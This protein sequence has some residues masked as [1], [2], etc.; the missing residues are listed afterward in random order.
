MPTTNEATGLTQDARTREDS[1]PI[2]GSESR[3]VIATYPDYAGAERAVD[4]LSD[5]GFAV[6]HVAIVGKG[7]RS[8]EQVSSRMSGARAALIGAGY[9]ALIGALFA[10]LFGIFFDGPNFGGLLLYSVANGVIFG[11]LLAGMYYVIESDGSRDFVSETSIVADRYEVHADE[12]VADEAKRVLSTM[13]GR[14]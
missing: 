12:G 11:A 1:Q 13:P 5:Q 2:T 7:L 9:G 10:L 3:R 6:E 8:V 14:S 4:W